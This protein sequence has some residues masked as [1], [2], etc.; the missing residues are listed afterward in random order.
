MRTLSTKLFISNWLSFSPFE[1]KLEIISMLFVSRKKCLAKCGNWTSYM[2]V[3]CILF[4]A[5]FRNSKPVADT[6][7]WESFDWNIHI[8]SNI[9]FSWRLLLWVYQSNSFYVIAIVHWK[10]YHVFCVLATV[11]Y[12]SCSMFET[13]FRSLQISHW[14][15]IKLSCFVF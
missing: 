13:D 7:D 3:L 2:C 9:N 1:Q 14:Y 8:L 15:F 10:Q 6:N 11:S 5:Y 4:F 12:D